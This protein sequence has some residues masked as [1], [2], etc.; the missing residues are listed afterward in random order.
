MEFESESPLPCTEMEFHPRPSWFSFFNIHVPMW[1]YILC[2]GLVS[3]VPSMTIVVV[4]V[5]AGVINEQTSPSFGRVLN[6]AAEFVGMTI[7]SPIAETF[8]MSFFLWLMSFATKRRIVLAMMSAFVWAG[9]HSMLAPAWGFG[10]LWPFFV[11]SCA[12]LAWRRKSWFH[13]I[14]AASC[15]HMLQNLIPATLLISGI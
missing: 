7:F 14:L 2:M 12:Y 15:V 3:F 4:L 5:G 10:V 6:P 13:A 1:K 9:L 8:L 11:M